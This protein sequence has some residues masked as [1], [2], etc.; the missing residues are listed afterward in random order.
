MLPSQLRLHLR[1]VEHRHQHDTAD[2]IPRQ[3]GQQIAREVIG[4][5]QWPGDHGENDLYRAGD[6]VREAGNTDDPGERDD[7][8]EA[9]RAGGGEQPDHQRDQPAGEDRAGEQ[10]QE[11]ALCRIE[12]ER[13]ERG[14]DLWREDA[15]RG[16]KREEQ[17]AEQVCGEDD[18]PEARDIAEPPPVVEQGQ[19]D[20]ERGFGKQLLPPQHDDEEA[21]G[22]AQVRHERAPRRI[23]EVGVQ[24]PFGNER[25][26]H[27]QPGGEARPGDRRRGAVEL[28]FAL[29]ADRL[30]DDQ[31]A[32][33][34]APLGLSFLLGVEF[35]GYLFG[36][37]HAGVPLRRLSERGRWG[38]RDAPARSPP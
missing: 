27:R 19:H 23:G 29:D 31:R 7:D 9:R 16:S 4:P 24:Y 32:G 38:V 6:D 2:N 15:G 35:L 17:C 10:R 25:E 30:V 34:L 36:S 14:A 26:A 22:V 13:Q 11:A 37:G 12:P 5:A 28:L 18:G 33:V 21:R 1:V 20:V 8:E 3:Y